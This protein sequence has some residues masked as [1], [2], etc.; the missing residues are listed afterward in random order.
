MSDTDVAIL[1]LPLMAAVV[2]VMECSRIGCTRLKRR[3]QKN[4]SS[5]VLDRSAGL[6]RSTSR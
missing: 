5:A 1:I 3:L 6:S 4:R 2:V